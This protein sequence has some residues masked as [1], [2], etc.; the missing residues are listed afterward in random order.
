MTC[1]TCGRAVTP[2]SARDCGRHAVTR[3]STKGAT[4]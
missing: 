1:K 2:F 4:R 3:T